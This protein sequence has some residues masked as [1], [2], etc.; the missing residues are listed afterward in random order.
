MFSELKVFDDET[1]KMTNDA[2]KTSSS[3]L[4]L[5]HADEKLKLREEH[6]KELAD[7]MRSLDPEAVSRCDIE[8]KIWN[9]F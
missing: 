5:H 7:T 9:L 3:S 6:L 2:V 4:A 1:K 8:N